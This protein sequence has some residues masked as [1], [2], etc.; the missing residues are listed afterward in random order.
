MCARISLLLII[1]LDYRKNFNEIYD[2]LIF[3]LNERFSTETTAFLNICENFIT[4]KVSDP[5]PIIKFYKND[6]EKDELKLHR[7]MFLDIVKQRKIEMTTLKEVV[8]F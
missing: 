4:G 5:T 8:T 6:F 7:D 2:Q 1:L 3:S